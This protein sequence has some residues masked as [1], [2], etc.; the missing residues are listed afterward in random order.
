[1]ANSAITAP[2]LWATSQTGGREVERRGGQEDDGCW[3]VDAERKSS[4]SFAR[5]WARTGSLSQQFQWGKGPARYSFL[6]TFTSG[7]RSYIQTSN[8][9][10]QLGSVWLVMIPWIA[11]T[12]AFKMG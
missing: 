5:L 12:M 6:R 10:G 3:M 4:S 7:S 9:S 2:L 1:M 8:L 11:A